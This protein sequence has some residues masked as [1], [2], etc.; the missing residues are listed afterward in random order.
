[1]FVLILFQNDFF[2]VIFYSINLVVRLAKEFRRDEGKIFLFLGIYLVNEY[3][4]LLFYLLKQ[5]FNY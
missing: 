2:Y 4:L 3:Y 1:M 5:N